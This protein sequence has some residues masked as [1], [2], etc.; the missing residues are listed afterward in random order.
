MFVISFKNCNDDPTRNSFDE[1][2]MSLVKIKEFNALIDNK[3]FFD[4]SV[5]NKQEA[6]KESISRNDDY[7]TWNL[8]DYLYHQ[9]YYKIIGIDFWRQTNTSIPQQFN[10]LGK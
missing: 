10:F 8:L 1:Y 3:P 2:Y 6:Y 9:K 7:T 4:Q 5:K